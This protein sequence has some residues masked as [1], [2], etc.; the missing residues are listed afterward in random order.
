[1]EIKLDLNKELIK[2]PSASFYVRV[3]GNSM[4]NAGIND[5]D[6]L[7]VDRALEVK[8]KDIVICAI[9]GVFTVKRIRKNGETILLEPENPSFQAIKITE[10]NDFRVWGV[11]SYVIH[12]T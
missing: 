9:N 7:I 5:G 11:V 2:H 12:K 6:I 8:N 3:K 1:M 4:L 10:E